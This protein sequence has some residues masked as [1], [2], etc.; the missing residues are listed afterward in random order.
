MTFVVVV[1]G[2]IG[3]VTG[4]YVAGLALGIFTAFFGALVSPAYSTAAVFVVLT[5]VLMLRPGGLAVSGAAR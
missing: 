4:S 3:S 5:L 2:G 1:L